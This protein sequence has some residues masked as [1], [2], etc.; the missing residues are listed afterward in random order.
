MKYCTSFE[1]LAS[2]F[3][4]DALVHEKVFYPVLGG[5]M[6]KPKE[7]KAFLDERKEEE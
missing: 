7:L 3:V 4:L 6:V 2:M 5:R 1:V